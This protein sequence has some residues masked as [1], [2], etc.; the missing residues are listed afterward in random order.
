MHKVILSMWKVMEEGISM[1]CVGNTEATDL[2]KTQGLYYDTMKNKAGQ[3]RGDQL[4]QKL[5]CRAEECGLEIKSVLEYTD[6]SGVTSGIILSPK[7]TCTLDGN[8]SNK[9]IL[10]V[11]QMDQPCQEASSI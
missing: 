2:P 10:Q 9:T 1:A 4:A 7:L 5:E 11:M 8:Y 3:L 6:K